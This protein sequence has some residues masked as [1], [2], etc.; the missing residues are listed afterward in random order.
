M[1]NTIQNIV[2]SFDRS[3]RNVEKTIE[4]ALQ[5]KESLKNVLTLRK[6]EIANEY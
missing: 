1:N 2:K 5:K 3:K 4:E 6:E